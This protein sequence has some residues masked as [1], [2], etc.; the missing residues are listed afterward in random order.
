MPVSR[1]NIFEESLSKAGPDI[2][3]DFPT[4]VIKATLAAVRYKFSNLNDLVLPFFSQS[5]SK[6]SGVAVCQEAFY[7]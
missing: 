5:Y 4:L 6:Q 2:R 7:T 3:K 1:Y